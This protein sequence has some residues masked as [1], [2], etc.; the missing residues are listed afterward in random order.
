MQDSFE[1]RSAC[2]E[3]LINR[4]EASPTEYSKAN[5]ELRKIRGSMKL[6]NELRTKQKVNCC[7]T[8]KSF[9]HLGKCDMPTK[10]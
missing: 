4:P 2:L 8:L 7:N 3:N 6:I 5:K 9:I 1:R 10:V